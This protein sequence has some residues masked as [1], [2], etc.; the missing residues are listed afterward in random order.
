MSGKDQEGVQDSGELAHTAWSAVAVGW[1]QCLIS[2][3]LAGSTCQ[4][5]QQPIY[6][7]LDV[8]YK[9]SKTTAHV[10]GCDM[11]LK[12]EFKIASGTRASVQLMSL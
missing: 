2:G 1:R 9:I 5:N 6:P 10:G 12:D 3:N 7:L 11:N 4:L 8:I